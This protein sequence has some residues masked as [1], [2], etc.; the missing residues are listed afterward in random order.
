MIIIT[1]EDLDFPA[2]QEYFQ[3]AFRV[4]QISKAGT[5]QLVRAGAKFVLVSGDPSSGG[6]QVYPVRTENE[7]RRLAVKL[8][9]EA[10]ASGEEV[11][12]EPFT[13]LMTQAP[14]EG[15]SGEDNSETQ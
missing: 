12:V 10:K 14:K 4:G 15:P 5:T 6:I 9:D 11:Q 13:C 3:H 8:L 2:L 1:N 7:A